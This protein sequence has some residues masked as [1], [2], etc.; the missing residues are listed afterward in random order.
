MRV[1]V[2]GLGNIGTTLALTLSREA[3]GLGIDEV[4]AF[5]NKP[6]PWQ[7]PELEQLRQHGV[8][9]F[10]SDAGAAL[11][12]LLPQVSYVF[13]AREHGLGLAAK[14]LYQSLIA[15]PASR[16][17]GGSAQGSEK[18]FGPS[19]M[20]GLNPAPIQRQPFANIVSCN[21][22]GF[23]SVLR[24]LTGDDLANLR[25]AD[26]VVA[27][28]SEDLGSKGRLVA[29]NVIAR[30]LNDTEGSHHAI[31]AL[32]LFKTQGLTPRLTSSDITTPSQAMHGLRFALHLNTP[33]SVADASAALR[34]SPA[35]AVTQKFD[36]AEIFAFGRRYG[37][38][39]RLYNHAIVVENQLWA[40]GDMLRGWAFVPQEG[41]TILS[42]LAAFAHQ[43]D[44]LDAAGLATLASRYMFTEA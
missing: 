13:E 36:S 1:L 16:L 15:D 20:W 12:T 43:T 21:T 3:S 7:G 10:R 27:R 2:N 44:R 26:A 19:Y 42:T 39:G 28:R 31:D 24:A 35:L 6:Q 18:G 23:A 41:C 32:D 33:L 5:K 40:D 22:H 29:A 38:Q 34:A 17:K 25:S 30:H 4:W 14:P 9:V 37:F 8:S 11:E